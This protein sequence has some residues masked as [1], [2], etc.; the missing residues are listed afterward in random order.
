MGGVGIRSG[1][2]FDSLLPD[3]ST[4]ET[5]ARAKLFRW[6]ALK[7][8]VVNGRVGRKGNFSV[9]CTKKFWERGEGG[10]GGWRLDRKGNFSVVCTQKFVECGYRHQ[11]RA[12]YAILDRPRPIWVQTLLEAFYVYNPCIVLVFLRALASRCSF[13]G[14]IAEYTKVVGITR[15]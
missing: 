6:H 3:V 4:G 15:S 9:V 5:T 2:F 1:I 11:R 10:S 14:L 8:R 12:L 7:A 13:E